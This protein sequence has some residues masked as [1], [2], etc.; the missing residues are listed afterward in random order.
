IGAGCGSA[1][2]ARERDRIQRQN[3]GDDVVLDQNVLRPAGGCAVAVNDGRIVDQKTVDALAAG[4]GRR[5]GGER[6]GEDGTRQEDR[7]G[8]GHGNDC[9]TTRP[10][11]RYLDWHFQMAKAFGNPERTFKKV[12][13]SY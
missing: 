9:A 2:T 8:T 10:R 7:D 5:L 4:G 12:V 3:V 1:P 13:E 6:S 11:P